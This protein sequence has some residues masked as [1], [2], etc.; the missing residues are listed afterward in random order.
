M[1]NSSLADGA[2]IS[3][4]R[5]AEKLGAGGFCGLAASWC[6]ERL[7]LSGKRSLF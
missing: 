5:I 4:Y 2:T 6:V 7:R 3:H 1:D